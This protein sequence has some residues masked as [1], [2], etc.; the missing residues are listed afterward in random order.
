MLDLKP[1]D[2]IDILKFIY[3]EQIGELNFRRAREF[4]IFAWSGAIFIGLIALLLVFKKTETVIWKLYG[5]EGKIIA[6]FS[7]IALGV[8][9][10]MWQNR[11]RSFGNG[12]AR[13]VAKINKLLHCFDEGYF[14]LNNNDTLFP[15]EWVPWGQANIKSA[16]RMFRANLVTATWF[17]CLLCLFMIWVT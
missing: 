14:G 13:V 5:V 16:R 6:S 1:E 7:I 15:L 3:T 2:K 12:N 8:F 11:E 10:I 4:K 17:L 9:S